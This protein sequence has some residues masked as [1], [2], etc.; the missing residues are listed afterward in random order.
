MVRIDCIPRS[1]LHS[2]PN[3]YLNSVYCS[4]PSPSNTNHLQL[5]FP[6][7]YPV[8]KDSSCA[9]NTFA[10]SSHPP[11]T[12]FHFL[13][14]DSTI[15]LRRAYPCPSTTLFFPLPHIHPSPP[16]ANIIHGDRDEAW[17]ATLYP[18]QREP[19]TCGAVSIFIIG[20]VVRLARCW[21]G[22]GR[23]HLLR[24]RLPIAQDGVRLARRSQKRFG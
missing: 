6:P 12:L 4:N 23:C 21:S 13:R 15:F 7:H 10:P 22:R 8:C 19:N 24:G 3:S 14:C 9:R 18:A 16:C 1:T 5:P 20:L 11:T 2:L 17:C